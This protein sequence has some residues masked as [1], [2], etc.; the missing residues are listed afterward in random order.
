MKTSGMVI[1]AASGLTVWCSAGLVGC[2]CD[3][4]PAYVEFHSPADARAW[5]PLD[6]LVF[7]PSA[8]VTPDREP[9]TLWLTVRH[10]DGF[11]YSELRLIV[12]MT[13]DGLPLPTDTLAL[14]LCD[15]N[16]RWSGTGGRGVYSLSVQ[17]DSAFDARKRYTLSIRPDSDVPLKGIQAVGLTMDRTDRKQDS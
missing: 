3:R 9:G 12:E 16:G 15:T 4:S 1:A 13:E 10:T 11:A 8:S 14:K 5:D 6:E 2:D 7:T 17:L